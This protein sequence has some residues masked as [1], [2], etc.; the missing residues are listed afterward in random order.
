MNAESKREIRT[1]ECRLSVRE[2]TPDETAQGEY[3]D[4]CA[5]A[6]LAHDEATLDMIMNANHVYDKHIDSENMVARY[7][8]HRPMKV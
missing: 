6:H 2:A 1:L 5:S 4:L 3:L 7:L 8:R